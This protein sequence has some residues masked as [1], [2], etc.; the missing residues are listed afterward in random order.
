MDVAKGFLWGMVR[1]CIDRD[2]AQDWARLGP[3]G[4]AIL[5]AP[6]P[7]RSAATRWALDLSRRAFTWSLRQGV[8]SFRFLLFA[9]FAKWLLL[10]V[11][12]SR[13]ITAAVLGQDPDLQA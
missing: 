12:G 8:G 10:K 11:M 13:W 7:V 4:W 6:P 1:R 3:V 9:K 2:P 5:R